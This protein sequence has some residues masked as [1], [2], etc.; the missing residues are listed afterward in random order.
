MRFRVTCKAAEYHP[1]ADQHKNRNKGARARLCVCGCVF[2]RV[3]VCAVD[4]QS[5]RQVPE[6]VQRVI[7]GRDASRGESI[8]TGTN[9]SVDGNCSDNEARKKNGTRQLRENLYGIETAAGSCNSLSAIPPSLC[10]R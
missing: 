7:S 6:M 2:V 1:S 3:C 4:R 10:I 8:R 9:I 5:F